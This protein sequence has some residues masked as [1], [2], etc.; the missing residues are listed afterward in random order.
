VRLA[1]RVRE[2]PAWQSRAVVWVT[3][4]SHLLTDV[5]LAPTSGGK[6]NVSQGP[7]RAKMRHSSRQLVAVD[8]K[9]VNQEDTVLQ[10]MGATASTTH[11]IEQ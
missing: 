6:A 2:L 5:R 7:L 3:D 4:R 10:R 1:G 11:Q 9:A 8:W